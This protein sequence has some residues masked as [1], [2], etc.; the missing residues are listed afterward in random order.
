MAP[1]R[2]DPGI[3][4]LMG[5]LRRWRH[6]LRRAESSAGRLDHRVKLCALQQAAAHRH[7][8]DRHCV[9]DVREGIGSKDYEVSACCRGQLWM[10]EPFQM[11]F[12]ADVFVVQEC[13]APWRET[14]QCVWFGEN[15]RQSIAVTTSGAYAVRALPRMRSVPKFAFPV[16]IT[17]PHQQPAATQ[18]H[19][20]CRPIAGARSCQRLSCVHR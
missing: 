12:S 4:P 6:Q 15:P 5:V 8:L 10:K 2:S 3:P 18:P 11:P 13:A 7:P 20:A 17:A 9:P 16:E 19:G 14:E 1:R